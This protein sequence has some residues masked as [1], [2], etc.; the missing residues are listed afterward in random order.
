MPKVH[1]QVPDVPIT[2]STTVC[3]V[4]NNLHCEEFP[5]LH[6]IKRGSQEQNGVF[7]FHVFNTGDLANA[8]HTHVTVKVYT[9][10]HSP[11]HTLK[12]QGKSS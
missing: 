1:L 9:C 12:Q 8:K 7:V 11:F 6:R 10:E 3:F 4:S 2:Q 5:V